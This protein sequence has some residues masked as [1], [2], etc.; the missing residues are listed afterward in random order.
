MTIMTIHNYSR[1]ALLMILMIIDCSP[2]DPN[3]SGYII[4]IVAYTIVMAN[5]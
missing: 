5:N 4:V 2:Y 1:Y 3:I